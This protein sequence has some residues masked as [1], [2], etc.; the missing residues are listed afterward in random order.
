MKPL[1]ILNIINTVHPE[2]GGVLEWVLQYGLAAQAAGHDIH[3]ASMD[4]PAA[5][6]V[7]QFPLPIHALGS[8]AK[9]FW[10]SGLIN[11]LKAHAAEYDAVIAHGLWRFS[12]YGTRLGLK[13]QK[14]PYFLYTH[15]MLDPWF[16]KAYPLKT[17]F[18]K[19]YYPFTEY[20]ALRDARGVI[21]T[22]QE[23]Q[24]LAA[25]SFA[26]YKVNPMVLPLG[27]VSPPSNVDGQRDAFFAQYP[28]LN[29]KRLLLFISRI[30]PKKGCDLLLDAFAKV[31][32]SNPELHLVMAGPDQTGWVVK[33]Q[34][35]AQALGIADRVTWTGMITGDVKWGAFR[36][37]EAFVLPS[38][39]ENFGFVVVEA[40][41]CGT[42]VLISDKVNIHTEVTQAGAG[43]VET[44]DADGT[45]R[46]LTRWLALNGEERQTLG[47][48]GLE[49]FQHR[50]EISQ[51]AQNL[52]HAI[53]ASL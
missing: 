3:M 13:G 44:D 16:N 21:F 36:A 46:L 53:T 29:G 6:F 39:Q 7:A 27:I 41:A 50:F 48:N 18:K 45:L 49:G 12:S 17:V 11:F 42:P 20:P 10:S 51:A 33:L 37:A 9:M 2:T 23:E 15:G 52:M 25:T 1:K 26:P 32:D 43:L 34:E 35:Q 38:H 24:R 22:C 4:D 8:Q 30:H 40:M 14:T 28:E 19:L 47:Q 31:A 5:E